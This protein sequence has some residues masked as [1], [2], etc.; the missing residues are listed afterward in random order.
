MFLE[1]GGLESAVWGGSGPSVWGVQGSLR[2][3]R[4]RSRLGA[5]VALENLPGPGPAGLVRPRRRASSGR[6][7]IV[8]L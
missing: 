4:E 6:N 5:S 3:G 7:R 1:R 2:T 8:S